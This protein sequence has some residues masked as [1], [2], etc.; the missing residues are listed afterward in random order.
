MP[1]LHASSFVAG[2]LLVL[3]TGTSALA[4]PVRPVPTPAPTAPPVL[5]PSV[6]TPAQSRAMN[7]NDRNPFKP[8]DAQQT[9]TPT[10]T[11][12]VMPM[13]Q[14]PMPGMPRQQVSP[15]PEPVV[16]A[17]VEEPKP[18][19]EF[20]D[21]RARGTYVGLIDGLE[22]WRVETRYHLIPT[23]KDALAASERALAR[24]KAKNKQKADE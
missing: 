11:V 1:K 22:L 18:V 3:M 17:P 5:A 23:E 21:T 4:Q 14:R 13:P 15:E 19:D 6:P 9:V 16:E 10:S 2:C 12:P 20:A 8:A 7:R 24:E